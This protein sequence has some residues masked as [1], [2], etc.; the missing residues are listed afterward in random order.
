MFCINTDLT[1]FELIT[2]EQIVSYGK[3]YILANSFGETMSAKKNKL[4]K[5]IYT[6]T[7]W[8]QLRGVY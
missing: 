3:M 2:G 6:R 7:I 1:F 4:T 5:K 8:G